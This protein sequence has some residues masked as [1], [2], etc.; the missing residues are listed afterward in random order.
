MQLITWN[1]NSINV[2]QSQLESLLK[3][4]A[5]DV[6]GLQEIKCET[7]QFPFDAIT[8]L[9]YYAVASGQK[10]Y[11]GV[12]LISR[13]E[14]ID[15]SVGLP[16]YE[17]DQQRVIAATINGVRVVNVYVPNGQEV[18]SEK[19]AYK[20]AWLDAFHE[21]LAD[22]LAQ[23]DTV[24]V[25]GDFNIVPTDNDVYAPELWRDKI[26]CSPP[27]RAAFEGLLSLGFQDALRIFAT[28]DPLFTW[29]DYRQG[30]F[31]KDEGMRIDHFLLSN[32]ASA[33]MMRAKV[34]REIRALERPSDHAPVAIYLKD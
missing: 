12:A 28:N 18:D 24:V 8:Q 1:V 34:H 21:Y 10:S 27:E 4:A 9:G 11:N 15:V 14:P 30:Q 26:L 33:R 22:T 25:M 7:A 16:N 31:E 13:D 29:W 19:Y 6:V 2:R 5:P 17:D 20:L 32:A 23:Y 3:D